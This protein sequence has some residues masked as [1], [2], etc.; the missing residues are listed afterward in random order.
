M[1]KPQTGRSRLSGDLL[2][3]TS[4]LKGAATALR[5]AA[6]ELGK[7]PETP[8]R[9]RLGTDVRLLREQVVDLL[10][11]VEDVRERRNLDVDVDPAGVNE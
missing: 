3:A 2:E 10:L 6:T 5:S 7:L 8:V 4:N 9:H 1:S 11:Q